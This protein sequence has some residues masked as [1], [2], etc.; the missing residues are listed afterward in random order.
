MKFKFIEQQ[1]SK[2]NVLARRGR[3]KQVIDWAH[4]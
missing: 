1:A 2:D 3:K 4:R